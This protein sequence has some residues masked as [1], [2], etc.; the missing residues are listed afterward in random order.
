MLVHSLRVVLIQ[1][2]PCVLLLNR[3]KITFA[4]TTICTSDISLC[5]LCSCLSVLCLSK[6]VCLW[7]LM[8]RPLDLSPLDFSLP[9]LLTSLFLPPMTL[10][11][12]YQ[13]TPQ[14]ERV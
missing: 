9:S 3:E 5:F 4:S 8:L 13:L 6:C 11:P 7:M 10:F 2:T 14:Y 12:S 1:R